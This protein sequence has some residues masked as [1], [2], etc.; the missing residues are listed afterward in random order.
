[1]NKKECQNSNGV[2]KC[3]DCSIYRECNQYYIELKE[4]Y[5]RVDGRFGKIPVWGVETRNE[6]FKMWSKYRSNEV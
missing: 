4:A 1:M 5:R 3:K 6:M 2:T